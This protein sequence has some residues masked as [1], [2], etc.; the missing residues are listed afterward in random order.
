MISAFLLAFYQLGTKP[1]RHVVWVGLIGSLL[2]FSLLWLTIGFVLANSNI[3]EF[4]GFLFFLNNILE[5]V[6]NISVGALTLIFT[7]LLFPSVVSIIV[8]LFLEDVAQAVETKY[9]P[10]LAPP[11]RQG[12]GEIIMITTKFTAIS[13]ALNICALPVIFF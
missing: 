9:Y 11:R 12:A 10:G 7:L 13:L 4:T 5:W 2:V 8:S 6:F 3:L 1:F